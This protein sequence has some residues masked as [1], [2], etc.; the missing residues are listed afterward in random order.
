M[1]ILLIEDNT[2][3][4][5]YLAKG[6]G[7]RGHAVDVAADGPDGLLRATTGSYDILIVDRMLPRLDG[8][9]LTKMLRAADV[10]TPIL[11]LTTMSGI[12]DRV[13]GLEAGGDDYLVKPF[14]FS[15]LIARINALARRSQLKGRDAQA[16]KLR[17]A[18]MELDLLSRSVTR[19]GKRIDLQPQEFKLLEYLV[20]HAGQAVTRTMLLEHVWNLQF[21]PHTNVVETNLSR[22]R[23][24]IDRGF[25]TELI[26][27]IRGVGYC[28]RAG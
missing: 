13:E 12:D 26:Q 5:S 14:A 16:S 24:K 22:L 2:E 23:A 9:K 6:L 28:V 15:E 4:A 17:V 25:E 1:K 10:D 11:F 8:L 3:T 21:E 20:R 18:E 27:T 19:S 7:E